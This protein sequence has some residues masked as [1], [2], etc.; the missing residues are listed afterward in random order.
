MTSELLIQLSLLLPLVAVILIYLFGNIPNLREACTLVISIALFVFTVMLARRV[1]AGEQVS[2]GS[3][4]VM[5]GFT[6]EFSLEPLGMLFPLAAGDLPALVQ[7][8][9]AKR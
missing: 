2:W 3:V 4:D 7:A 6:I 8:E 1:E 9:E 5:A